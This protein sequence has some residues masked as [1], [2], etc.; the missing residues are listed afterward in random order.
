MCV[1]RLTL[2]LY[3]ITIDI[4]VR[5][6][7]LRDTTVRNEN[8]GKHTQQLNGDGD[9]GGG[10]INLIY[11][12]TPEQWYLTSIFACVYFLFVCLRKYE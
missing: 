2:V 6:E 11:S 1:G 5:C 7:F 8:I 12:G 4:F 9:G 10:D 3:H